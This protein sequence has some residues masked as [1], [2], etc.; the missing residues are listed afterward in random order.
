MVREVDEEVYERSPSLDEYQRWY[1]PKD[2]N[3]LKKTN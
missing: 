1:L 3:I 2:Q